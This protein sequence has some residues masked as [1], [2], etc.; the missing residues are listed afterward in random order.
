MLYQVDGYKVPAWRHLARKKVRDLL[1]CFVH[2]RR[3]KRQH[4]RIARAIYQ[5]SKKRA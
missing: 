5:N 4:F 1:L 3:Q 2:I